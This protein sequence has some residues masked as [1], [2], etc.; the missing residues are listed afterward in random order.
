[1]TL[2]NRSANLTAKDLEPL[3]EFASRGCRNRDLVKVMV[4]DAKLGKSFGYGRAHMV[5]PLTTTT[6]KPSLVQVWVTPGGRART[7]RAVPAMGPVTVA[8]W[9]EEFLLVLAHELRH[10]D[11]FWEE[12]FTEDQ[13]AASERDAEGHARGV[14]RRYRERSA[15][16]LGA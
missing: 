3:V 4:L 2:L 12:R 14:L 6:D 8:N 15:V 9:E 1:M 7:S 11:Q 13:V 16:S 10:I 5:S